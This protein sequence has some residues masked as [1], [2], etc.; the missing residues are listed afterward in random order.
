MTRV[1]EDPALIPHLRNR[2]RFHSAYAEIRLAGMPLFRLSEAARI[3]GTSDDSVRRWAE[4]G[5]LAVD[6]DES[7]RLVVDG[8]ELARMAREL[9]PDE[10]VWPAPYESARNHFPGIVTSVRKDGLMAQVEI[11]AGPHRVV[12]LMSR[13]AAEELDLQ[14][15][16]AA[17]A[18]VKATNVV[19][20]LPGDRS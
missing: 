6:R 4:K 12:S 18:S 7:G 3:L 8:A 16:S 15:G 13:E 19:V 2:F 17:I 11:Q 14:V 20:D 1:G 5:H 9:V 10:S